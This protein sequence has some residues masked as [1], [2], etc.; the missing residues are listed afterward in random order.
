MKIGVMIE[1]LADSEQE[2]AEE[3]IKPGERHAADQDVFHLTKTLAKIEQGH[4]DALAPH[5]ERYDVELGSPPERTVF[6]GAR[7]L[8]RRSEPALLL[9]RDL[10]GLHLLAAGAS[11]DWT[12]LGQAAQAAGDS[13]LLDVVT[14][15][16]SETLRTLKWTTYRLKEAA[17]QALTGAHELRSPGRDTAG[18][19]GPSA[20]ASETGGRAVRSRATASRPA[21]A[22]TVP[23]NA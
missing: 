14:T 12:A 7:L 18:R 8:G 16:D 10:R 4:I 17:P 1:Q 6:E 15:G 19:Q 5:A 22:E 13:Q 20:A 11:L 2:L 21:A 3:L 23:M 9:L